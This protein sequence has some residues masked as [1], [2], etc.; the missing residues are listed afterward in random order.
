MNSTLPSKLSWGVSLL[1]G[2][3]VLLIMAAVVQ[4]AI[5]Q[6]QPLPVGLRRADERRKNMAEL[7]QSNADALNNFAWIDQAKG[8]V[9]IPIGQSIELMREEWQN[10]AQG[11]KK[12]LARIEKANAV[13]PNAY[14]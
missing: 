11:R 5:R 6:T 3:G 8:T 12:L 10:P 14:E 4:I 2:M 9:R 1:G 7:R 13:M